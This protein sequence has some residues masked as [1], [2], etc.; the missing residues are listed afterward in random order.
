MQARRSVAKKIGGYESNK[1]ASG[2]RRMRRLILLGLH[3]NSSLAIL[4][5]CY[6]RD[7]RPDPG[8]LEQDISISDDPDCICN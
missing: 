6:C 4:R 8:Q 7:F 2:K 1:A 5:R 3:L